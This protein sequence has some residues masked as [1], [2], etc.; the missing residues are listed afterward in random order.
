[1]L[2]GEGTW[3]PGASFRRPAQG[4]HAGLIQANAPRAPTAAKKESRYAWLMQHQ[5][6]ESPRIKNGASCRLLISFGRIA[7]EAHIVPCKRLDAVATKFVAH[8]GRQSPMS[9]H[10]CAAPSP[11]DLAVSL[12]RPGAAIVPFDGHGDGSGF[13]CHSWETAAVSRVC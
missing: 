9:V 10:Q 11:C 1:M 8:A 4:G 12:P 5:P 3:Q 13:S 7:R 2:S 6:C